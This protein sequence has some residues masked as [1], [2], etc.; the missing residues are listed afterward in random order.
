MDREVDFRAPR[1]NRWVEEEEGVEVKLLNYSVWH[2]GVHG[3]GASMLF[4]CVGR[5]LL[6]KK[7]GWREKTVL[8]LGRAT[9]AKP[10]CKTA[11]RR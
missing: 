7:M 5:E 3:V 8:V 4:N 2:E 9:S 6:R 11:F 10:G 1:L